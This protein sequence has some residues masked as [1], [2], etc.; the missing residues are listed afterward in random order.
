[1]KKSFK[2]G[3]D[4]TQKTNS[5]FKYPMLEIN[6]KKIH[7][8]IKTMVDLCKLNGINITGVVK[9]FN[10]IPEV[11]K[12]YEN[13]GCTYIASS[14]MNQII[15]LKEYGIQSHLCWLEFQCLVK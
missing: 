9:G 10:A 7:E 12:Q 1:M 2:G 15:K 11:V 4:M 14:R 8:N 3:T 6:L 5:N 13:A